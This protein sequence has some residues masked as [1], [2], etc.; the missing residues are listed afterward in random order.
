MANYV[1]NKALYKDILENWYPKVE[2]WI[3]GGKKGPPPPVTDFMGRCIYD[4]AVNFCRHRKF[5]HLKHIHDDLASY[6]MLTVLKYIHNFNPY[7]YNNPFAYITMIINNAFFQYIKKETKN[8]KSKTAMVE[9]AYFDQLMASDQGE[10]SYISLLNDKIGSDAKEDSIFEA[11]N[12][13]FK[14]RTTNE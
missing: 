14:S 8:N 6:G 11:A 2:K 12:E 7:K 10:E 13:A 5:F 4:T 9:Q 1:D 3:E